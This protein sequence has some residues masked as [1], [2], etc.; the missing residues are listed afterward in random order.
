MVDSGKSGPKRSLLPVSTPILKVDP[1]DPEEDRLQEAAELLRSGEVVALPT[2]TF[3]GLA[4][5]PFDPSAVTRLNALK[6][7]PEASPSLL[8]LA[9]PEQVDRVVGRLPESFLVLAEKFWPGPLT[10]V[11]PAS[12]HLPEEVTGGRGTVGI[13]VPGLGLPRRLAQLLGRP[14]T[15]VSANL[16]G[17]SPCLTA[18]EVVRAFQEGVA[19]VLDGGPA[20]GGAPSTVLDL[21]GREP[22]VIRPGAVPVASLR[23]LLSK[24]VE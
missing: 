16:H 11:V 23:P 2:E 6:G 13:R 21:T 12:E 17:R 24:L 3:Y 4:A 1:A 14:V 22:R 7:K 10:L 19:L 15:G 20:A 8:L 9:G 5:D 18:S